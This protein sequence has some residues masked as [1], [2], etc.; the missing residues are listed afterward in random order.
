MGESARAEV[1]SLAEN[2]QSGEWWHEDDALF[3]AY[4]NR[5]HKYLRE[6]MVIAL[7]D[8]DI[9]Q[10][11][12]LSVDSCTKTNSSVLKNRTKKNGQSVL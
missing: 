2:L 10:K 9:M 12:M 5:V 4:E 7:S 11:S 1:S 3:F 6:L 8:K